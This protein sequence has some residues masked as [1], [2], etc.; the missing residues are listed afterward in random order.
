M[1]KVGVL[2]HVVNFGTAWENVGVPVCAVN[3]GVA[4]KIIM[5]G[6]MR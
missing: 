5:C 1:E 3:Y 2:A 6:C 4:W